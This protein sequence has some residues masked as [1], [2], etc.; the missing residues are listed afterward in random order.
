VLKHKFRAIPTELDGIKFASKKEARRYR[1]LRLLE[2][3]GELL[4]FLRQVPFHLPANVKYVCDFLCFWQDDT[5]TV[6]D[7]K[8]IKMPMYVLKKKQVE[9]IYPIKI[10]EV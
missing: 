6:E 3:S 5:V 9:A 4:F 2:K 10:M 7:V 8:G 1:E